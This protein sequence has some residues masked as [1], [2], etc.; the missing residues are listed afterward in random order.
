[1]GE[2]RDSPLPYEVVI[3]RLPVAL[4]YRVSCI[5]PLPVAGH[6]V[7][8]SCIH[9]FCSTFVIEAVSCGEYVA[10]TNKGRGAILPASGS[11]NYVQL[12]YSSVRPAGWVES[13]FFSDARARTS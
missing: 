10:L 2:I 9:P 11:R 8:G 13:H 7:N 4:G 6:E 3:V 1:M 12:P 5:G